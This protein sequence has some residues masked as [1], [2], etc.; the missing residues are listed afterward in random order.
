M[1]EIVFSVLA[2]FSLVLMIS[3]EK[4]QEEDIYGEYEDKT[5]EQPD[6][7]FLPDEFEKKPD[8][9][10][11]V[12]NDS[13]PDDTTDTD[14][15]SNDEEPVDPY[16]D[17]VLIPQGYAWM[18][19]NE[20]VET[21]CPAAELPY[22]EIST[23]AY[24]IDK[25]EV[26]VSDFQKCID[27]KAC[28]D[29]EFAYDTVKGNPYCNLGARDTHPMNCVSY[30]G[31]AAYCLW[32]GKRLPS[33]GEWEKAA[34]GGCE[35]HGDENCE[36]KS[37]IYTWG[38]EGEPDC[39]KVNMASSASDWGCGSDATSVGGSYE[40]GKS[41]YGAYDMLGNLFEWVDDKWSDN[42]DG[43]KPDGSSIGTADGEA[44]IK[45][46]GFMQINKSQFR[47]SFRASEYTEQIL[48]SR[49][50]RCVADIEN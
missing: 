26:T 29:E 8:A 14:S 23:K 47:I 13:E 11:I 50:F 46:G 28:G 5:S 16:K 12:I 39:S 22:L 3:C 37:Y 2:L 17:M 40:A 32:K 41:P 45:G 21:D 27:A 35:I 42:H 31:A 1:K 34:R 24:Y 19:C 25:Y 48:Y 36:E 4:E 38:N 49:G 18:G 15:E 6:E 20:N 33:E 10:N 9:D 30:F 44:V 43:A 7:N